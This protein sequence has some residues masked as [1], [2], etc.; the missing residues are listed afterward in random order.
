MLK[1]IRIQRFKSLNDAMF[2]L[3]S[4][5]SHI[6][7]SFGYRL[8]FYPDN[9]TGEIFIGYIGPHLSKRS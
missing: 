4:L 3:A 6:K 2:P 5:S 1:F 8:H 9:E 7:M